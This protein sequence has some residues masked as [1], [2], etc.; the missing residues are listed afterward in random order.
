MGERE[1]SRGNTGTLPRSPRLG[2]P[3]GVS[4]QVGIK[5][6]RLRLQSPSSGLKS[7]TGYCM[8][9]SKSFKGKLYFQKFQ[10]PILASLSQIKLGR[11]EGRKDGRR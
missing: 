7:Q 10:A 11:M 8:P 9:K 5:T 4:Q 3:F 2:R 6:V 1:L